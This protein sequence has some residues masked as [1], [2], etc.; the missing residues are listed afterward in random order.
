MAGEYSRLD[1]LRTS[2]FPQDHIPPFAATATDATKIERLYAAIEALPAYP[3]N[4]FCPA[5]SG[6]FDHLV[7]HSTTL[8][9][10]QVDIE[11]G[12]CQGVYFDGTRGQPEKSIFSPRF[13]KLFAE[14]LGVPVS[15]VEFFPRS[16][17]TGPPAPTPSS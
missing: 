12:G 5:G 11:T 6:T 2:P 1:V 9:L 4:M 8:P 13:W 7:F 10:L 17:Y 15:T 16:Q 14:T 3:G